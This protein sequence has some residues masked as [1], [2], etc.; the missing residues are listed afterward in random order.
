MLL[1]AADVMSPGNKVCCVTS[2][3]CLFTESLKTINQRS[4]WHRRRFRKVATGAEVEL[5]IRGVIL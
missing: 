2:Q 1:I 4:Q 3:V 5:G